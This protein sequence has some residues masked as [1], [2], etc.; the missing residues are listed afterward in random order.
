MPSSVAPSA[1]CSRSVIF[2]QQGQRADLLLFSGT[3][4]ANINKRQE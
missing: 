1:V 3:N 4:T 2:S